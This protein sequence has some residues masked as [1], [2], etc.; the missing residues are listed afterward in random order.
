MWQNIVKWIRR[1]FRIYEKEIKSFVDDMLDLAFENVDEVIKVKL[2]P[3]IRKKV[4]SK[5]LADILVMGIDI[6]T[7]KGKS[8][9]GKIIMDAI[10]WFIKEG[11]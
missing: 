1:V 5:V 2:T 9:S 8:E 3:E 10:D 6:A 7:I 11:E 4:R